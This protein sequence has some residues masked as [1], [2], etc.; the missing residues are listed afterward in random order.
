MESVSIV[1]K[2]NTKL[3]TG[4][5]K[6]IMNQSENQEIHSVIISLCEST[7]KKYVDTYLKDRTR[8]KYPS[9]FFFP[10]LIKKMIFDYQI[11]R[12][13]NDIDFYDTIVKLETSS[14]TK[15]IY[16]VQEFKLDQEEILNLSSESEKI[17]QQKIKLVINKYIELFTGGRVFDTLDELYEYLKS[18]FP[19]RN[20]KKLKKVLGI[21]TKTIL[22][23]IQSRENITLIE[24]I[25]SLDI[26][27]SINEIIRL[28]EHLLQTLRIKNTGLYKKNIKINKK[29][30]ALHIYSWT[31]LGTAEYL[32]K[33]WYNDLISR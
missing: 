2:E 10:F 24:I 1:K 8:I 16:W 32:I 6:I 14:G 17:Y 12:D 21:Q 15:Y 28:E 13:N 11:F 22:Q 29:K 3:L 5:I 25:D 27:L 31:Q 7:I 30:I 26:L 9:I 19:D 4:K 23:H 18:N 20:N 33:E